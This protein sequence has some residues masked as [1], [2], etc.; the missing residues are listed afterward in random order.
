[1]VYSAE[2]RCRRCGKL[3]AKGSVRSGFMEIKCE[4]CGL[5]NVLLEQFED[6]V[7]ITDKKGVIL[8]VNKQVEHVTG[9]QIDEVI[10]KT[11]ALWGG[12]M[13]QEFYQEM[14]R[15]LLAEKSGFITRVTNKHK[16]GKLYDALLRVS[17]ILDVKGEI[18]FFV[19]MESLTP[20]D[21]TLPHLAKGDIKPL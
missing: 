15:T 7:I 1:M 9:Y 20:G 19:G 2:V 13:P 14:W 17:P 18:Q 21:L 16:S 8:F 4:R 10:G 11:P 5:L 6:Q 3:L 12:Q